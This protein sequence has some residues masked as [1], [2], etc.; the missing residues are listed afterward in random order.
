MHMCVCVCVCY[1]LV[2]HSV[3]YVKSVILFYS[4]ISL[5]WYVGYDDFISMSNVIVFVLIILILLLVL[6][7]AYMKMNILEKSLISISHDIFISSLF[8]HFFFILFCISSKHIFLIIFCLSVFL[9]SS[10]FTF[11]F[12][13]YH[14][15]SLFVW[16]D[17]ICDNMILVH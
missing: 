7:L 14:C 3:W 8:L 5:L 4:Y 13:M 10:I 6:L 2:H 17:I 11:S 12:S 16:F 1:I 9:S 15:Q